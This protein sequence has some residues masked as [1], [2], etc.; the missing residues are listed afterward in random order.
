MP[1][2]TQRY[3]RTKMVLP[4]RV[5][6]DEPVLEILPAQWAHTID[7]S[8][9]GCRLGG[10]RTELCPGQT[11][12]LQRGQQKIPFRVIWSK[13]LVANENQAGT[14]VLDYGRN[15][16]AVE[17]PSY[18]ITED[19]I[20]SSSVIEDCSV[21]PSGQSTTPRLT[22]VAAHPRMRRELIFGLLLLN[23]VLALS[24]YNETFSESGLI[25]GLLLLSI[26]LGLSLYYRRGAIQAPVP[27]DRIEVDDLR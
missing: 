24:I 3:P 16:W 12:S 9:I 20:D 7:I 17:L 23:P 13:H 5:W 8:Q 18:P 10:L 27:P 11:I 1:E 2:G 6:L 4:L 25:F 15:I 21:A 14:E 26:A 22:P 19:S